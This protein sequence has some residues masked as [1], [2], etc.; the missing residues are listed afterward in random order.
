MTVQKGNALAGLS[1][2]EGGVPKLLANS[3]LRFS[4]ACPAA[5]PRNEKVATMPELIFNIFK[6]SDGVIVFLGAIETPKSAK[7]ILFLTAKKLRA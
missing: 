2:L 1:L 5:T 3:K 6:V 4:K 7:S